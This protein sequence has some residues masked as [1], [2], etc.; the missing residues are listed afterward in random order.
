ML[1]P[2]DGGVSNDAELEPHAGCATA[3]E[4]GTA[5]ARATA[6]HAATGECERHGDAGQRRAQPRFSSALA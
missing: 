1:A 5:S 3:G 6:E 4:T 2:G